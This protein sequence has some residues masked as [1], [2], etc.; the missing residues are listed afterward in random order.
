MQVEAVTVWLLEPWLGSPAGSPE[1]LVK[2]KADDLI[3][4][5]VATLYDPNTKKVTAPKNR[6]VKAAANK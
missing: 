1:T 5:G 6:A 2:S 3:A 4:R